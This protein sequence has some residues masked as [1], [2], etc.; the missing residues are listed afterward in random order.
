MPSKAQEETLLPNQLIEPDE[1]R[2][3]KER[4]LEGWSM[5]DILND[6]GEEFITPLKSQYST[7]ERSLMRDR[8]RRNIRK[9]LKDPRV[10][11]PDI[12]EQAVYR[13][14]M[15]DR[16]VWIGLTHYE[17]Y[18]VVKMMEPVFNNEMHHPRWSSISGQEGVHE[19]SRKVGEPADRIGQILGKR[20]RRANAAA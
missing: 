7:Y 16:E 14:F 15:G 12:D 11:D 10:W 13:A 4:W 6:A 2:F 1:A 17:R 9:F 5:Q 8:W 20:R 19:W 18:Q 3:I